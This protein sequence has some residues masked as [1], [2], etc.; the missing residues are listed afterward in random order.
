MKR[1][2][3]TLALALSAVVVVTPASA[4]GAETQHFGFKA[5]FAQARFLSIDPSGCVVTDVFV[6]VIDGRIKAVGGPVFAP[7]AFVSIVQRDV[8][9]N[10]N[11]VVDEG[12]ADLAPDA[13]EVN[14]QLRTATLNT[15]IDLDEEGPVEVS[16]TWTGTGTAVRETRHFHLKMPGFKVNSHFNGLTRE[17]TASGTVSDGTTNF[18]PEPAV[19]AELASVRQGQVEIIH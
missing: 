17:A 7:E 2:F 6:F 19:S 16:V 10:I 12:V 8:C 11:L 9:A 5:E 15:T 13:F 4:A 18:T 3:L 1:L 14:G